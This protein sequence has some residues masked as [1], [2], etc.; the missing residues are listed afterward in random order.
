MRSCTLVMEYFSVAKI[1][2]I[3]SMYKFSTST[4]MY[5]FSF[6]SKICGNFDH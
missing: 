3:A 2:S 4:P 5:I 6:F 1:K